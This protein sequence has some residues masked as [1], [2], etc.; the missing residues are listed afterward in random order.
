M[1]QSTQLP[2]RRRGTLD[3][4]FHCKGR[5]GVILGS[6]IEQCMYCARCYVSEL[7]CTVTDGG[8]YLTSSHGTTACSMDRCQDKT[9][10]LYWNEICNG[11]VI[12]LDDS[13]TI[14]LHGCTGYGHGRPGAI[15][16]CHTCG[17]TERSFCPAQMY[18]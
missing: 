13:H 12:A 3:L 17:R 10:M 16:G 18:C 8:Y 11:V 9:L 15:L 7:I 1:S 5:P 6:L 2:W 4:L 14:A